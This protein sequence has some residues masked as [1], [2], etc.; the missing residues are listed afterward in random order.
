M[1]QN[2]FNPIYPELFTTYLPR[3]GAD[4]AHRPIFK[5]NTVDGPKKSKKLSCVQNIDNNEILKVT[6]FM[7][8]GTI[9][10]FARLDFSR[11][12]PHRHLPPR[13]K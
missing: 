3:G 6:K 12:G 8:C 4:A 2:S 13:R 1:A 7:T 10:L 5:G 11:D 9:G